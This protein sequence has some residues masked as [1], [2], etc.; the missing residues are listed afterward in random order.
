MAVVAQAEYLRRQLWRLALGVCV[1]AVAVLSFAH[2]DAPPLT[3]S[4]KLNHILAFAVLAWLAHGAYPQRRLAVA[5]WGLLLGYGLSIELI[6]S[7]LP[8]REAS[9]LD[10]A[11]DA[12]GILCYG[13]VALAGGKAVQPG[14][15][16]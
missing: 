10:V 9:W 3:H 11:A 6:Q 1:L 16:M 2:L 5:R 12:V 8:Y 14:E 4:D 15:G 13:V 7:F